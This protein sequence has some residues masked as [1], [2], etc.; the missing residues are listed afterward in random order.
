MGMSEYV[1]VMKVGDLEDGAMKAVNVEGRAVLVARV[2][3]VYYAADNKCPHLGGNLSQ[4]T[5]EGSVVTCPKHGSRFDLS[6]G[7][8]L[9]WTEWTGFKQSLAK[10]FKSPRSLVTYDTK[11][12]GDGILIAK[13]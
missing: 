7:H 3:D 1:E 13:K 2:G 10:T 4:G 5:L 9:L 11:V 6:D 12:E 8:V